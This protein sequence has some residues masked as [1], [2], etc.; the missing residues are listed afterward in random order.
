MRNWLHILISDEGDFKGKNITGEIKKYFLIVKRLI[1]Q[2]VITIPKVNVPNK[3]DLKIHEAKL[4]RLY[5]D[6]K[7][8]FVSRVFI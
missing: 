5:G 3:R 2:E 7:S 8:T 4:D 6:D 1:H